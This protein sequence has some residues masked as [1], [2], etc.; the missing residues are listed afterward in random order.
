MN[1]ANQ[2]DEQPDFEWLKTTSDISND[3]GDD[4]EEEFKEGDSPDILLNSIEIRKLKE[5]EEDKK[6][7]LSSMGEG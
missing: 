6:K 2:Q 3:G 7:I 5:M 1:P 4:Y